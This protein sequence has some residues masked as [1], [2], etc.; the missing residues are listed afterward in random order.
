M[1]LHTYTFGRRSETHDGDSAFH[2]SAYLH[3]QTTV[4]MLELGAMRYLVS[5]PLRLGDT[6]ID[7]P[8]RILLLAMLSWLQATFTPAA[9]ADLFN[10][11]PTTLKGPD[12]ITDASLSFCSENIQPAEPPHP[13]L[14]I[15][16]YYMIVRYLGAA[17]ISAPAA[18]DFGHF[19]QSYAWPPVRGMAL[20]GL[21]V[22]DPKDAWQ[23]AG[24]A[25]ATLDDS[26]AFQLH[27]YDAGSFIDTWTFRDDLSISGGGP[28]SIYGY[29]FYDGQTPLIFD[30]NPETDFVLQ[31]SVE[32]P[33]FA[34]WPDTMASA[35][36]EPVGEVNLFAYFRFRDRQ[37]R[38]EFCTAAGMRRYSLIP[39]PIQAV[40]GPGCDFFAL[41]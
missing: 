15:G 40:C 5:Y 39:R 6:L 14:P 22:P 25:D 41:M 10:F 31:A 29:S 11:Q 4:Q 30:D 26:S 34:V 9:A 18:S 8:R 1:R 35:G 27:C 20:T 28:H 3:P 16:R 37:S 38:Q 12:C 13:T 24:H 7:R 36:I 32:I 33:W 17:S 21:S 23:R 19:P 2:R